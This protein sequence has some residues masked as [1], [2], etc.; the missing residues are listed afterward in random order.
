MQQLE[1]EE[2]TD[3]EEEQYEGAFNFIPL[4]LLV[5]P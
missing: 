3:E 4:F 1:E 5:P 2:E